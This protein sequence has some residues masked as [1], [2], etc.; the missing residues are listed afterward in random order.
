M[1]DPITNVVTV[2]RG[3]K[4]MAAKGDGVVGAGMP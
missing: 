4:E 3:Q 1:G 2:T